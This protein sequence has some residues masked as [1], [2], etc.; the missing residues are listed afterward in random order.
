VQE[1]S[2][3]GTKRKENNNSNNNNNNNI[4]RKAVAISD[5][6]KMPASRQE[7][8]HVRVSVQD[9][10]PPPHKNL[11]QTVRNMLNVA[12]AA[13]LTGSKQTPELPSKSD[14]RICWRLKPSLS[15]LSN[16][17]LRL[18]TTPQCASAAHPHAALDETN[19]QTAGMAIGQRCR[20]EMWQQ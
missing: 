20:R 18:Q 8:W 14:D 9:Q 7:S 10:H 13:C 16:N 11:P 5:A 6:R 1:L 3:A 12:H 17:V 4:K 2:G 15:H 19:K